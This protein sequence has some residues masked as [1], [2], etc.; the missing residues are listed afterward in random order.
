MG[1]MQDNLCHPHVLS[2]TVWGVIHAIIIA[3]KKGERSSSTVELSLT[4]GRK[5][6]LNDRSTVE[7]S[8]SNGRKLS[9]NNRSTVELSLSNGRKSSLNDRKSR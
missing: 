6:S 3:D 4:N 9:F 2:T 5:S 7:L 8:L 1:I